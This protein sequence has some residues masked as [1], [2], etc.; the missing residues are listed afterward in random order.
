MSTSVKIM[1]KALA[2][3]RY[4]LQVKEAMMLYET[5]HRQH[6]LTGGG[7]A[8]PLLIRSDLLLLPAAASSAAR[9]VAGHEC[10]CDA[11]HLVAHLT[12]LRRIGGSSSQRWYGIAHKSHHRDL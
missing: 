6:L 2:S 12:H 1:L 8:S 11:V 4:L 5:V 7:Q 10:D 9:G 3:I